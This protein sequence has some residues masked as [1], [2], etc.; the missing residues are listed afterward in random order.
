MK[1]KKWGKIGAP[2][3]AKRRA[4]L[5]KLR[6]RKGFTTGGLIFYLVAFAALVLCLYS[7]SG[8]T[9]LQQDNIADTAATIQP[10]LDTVVTGGQ[11]ILQSP[12]AILIPE[13]IRTGAGILLI[14]LSGVSNLLQALSKRKTDKTLSAVT[15]A[16]EAA[17][18]GAELVKP[19]VAANLKNMGM[20]DAGKLI[21]SKAKQ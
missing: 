4:F 12:A 1:K 20:Y 19:L 18:I 17:P 9:P 10:P 7:M 3:S 2:K 6:K 13:P 5:S 14:C 21:I 15:K 16:V 11:T 8:C